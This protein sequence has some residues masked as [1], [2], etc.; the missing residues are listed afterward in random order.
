MTARLTESLTIRFTVRQMQL[1]RR[2]AAGTGRLPGEFIRRT[3]R[4]AFQADAELERLAR[5]DAQLRERQQELEFQGERMFSVLA[6]ERKRLNK[7][8]GENDDRER[9]LDIQE[10]ELLSL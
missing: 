7:I 2:K 8:R 5:I 9:I 4:D 1:V 3:L 6:D 10:S